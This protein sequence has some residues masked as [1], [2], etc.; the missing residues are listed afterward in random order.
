MSGIL[1]IEGQNIRET[2]G[3]GIN[4]IW[5]KHYDEGVRD[6]L[7]YP[8]MPAYRILEIAAEKY[9]DKVGTIF[10]GNQITY[11]QAKDASD[12]VA[13]F[14]LN[15]GVEKND[16]VMFALPNT[17]HAAPIMAGILKV[18]GI[19]VQCNPLY[20]QREMKFLAEDSGAKVM[21][22]M[23]M[24]YSN[25][26]P[27]L[28]DGT[29]EAVITCSLQDFMVGAAMPDPPEKRKGLYSWKNI[30]EAEK[31]D[32]RVEINPKEDVAMLQYTGGTTGFP[33]GVMLTHFNIVANAYQ[34]AN[35]DPKASSADVGIGMLPVFHSYGMTMM[36]VGILVGAT[37]I[38]MPDPRNYPMV[39][40]AI[41]TFR[42]TTLSAVPT[43]YIGML[44]LIEQNGYDLSSLRVC[45]SGAAPLPIEVKRRWEELTGKR[46][47]EGYG[48]SE[49]SPITHCNPI[50]GLNKEGSIGVPYPDTIAV[51]IDDD[52]NILPPRE[53]GELVIRGPQVMKGYWNRREETEKTL[54]NGWLLTG[55]M[56]KIDE[57]GYFYIV[58]RK[59]DMIIAGGYNIYPREIEEVLYE[60]PAVA[61]A[62]VVGVPDPYRG[63]TVKAFIELKPEW[64]G[65]VTEEDIIKF[66]KERLASYKVPRV[67]EFRDELPKS[68]VG[69]VLR[70]LLREEE[71]R[72][73]S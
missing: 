5:V 70:R 38:P 18:G 29:L 12:K 27:L 25:V 61:E 65:K 56:A 16:R 4:R 23:D 3:S 30:M 21:F 54:I 67:V 52:G 44:K 47:T 58:D 48:L 36:N 41:Q 2:D 43:M 63:E 8:V 40:Q 59:K 20:T 1:G 57:D 35:W 42:V 50:Y 37:I 51:V 24:M 10:F 55:D 19:I 6:K 72:R 32:R 26:S 17:P 11:K 69:K 68:L 62:A 28:D 39:L 33:K 73:R 71:M 66:C 60:H 46:I 64:K 45:T 34:A 49:A 13:A 14:L 9:G 15:L 31:T 7:D 22:C 53:V